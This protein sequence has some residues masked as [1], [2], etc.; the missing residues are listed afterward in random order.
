MQ[1]AIPRPD[2]KTGRVSPDQIRTITGLD[3]ME[4]IR[5]MDLPAPVSR[6]A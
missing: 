6:K 1:S 4:K 5:T 3:W 2:F